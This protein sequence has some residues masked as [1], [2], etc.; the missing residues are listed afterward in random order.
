[1]LLEGL[2]HDGSGQ[3]RA[4]GDKPVNVIVLAA[5]YGTRLYPLTLNTPKPLLAVGG[6]AILERILGKVGEVPA[7]ETILLVTN[8]RFVGH[9]EAWRRGFH[10]SRPIEILN[11]GTTTNENRLGAV[12]DIYFALKQK[13]IDAEVLV[14]GGDN[15]FE[16]D[17]NKTWGFF[18]QQGSSVVGLYDMV[19][20]AKV[21]GLYGVVSV[22]ETSRIIGFQEKPKDPKSALISTAIYFFTKQDLETLRLYIEEANSPDNLGDF[23]RYLI[24]RQTVYGYVFREE[25]FDIGSHDQYKTADAYFSTVPG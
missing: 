20:K 3:F 8:D 11:D 7:V 12:G 22:D 6:K 25:W 21:A 9:F 23:V 17:L 24:E 15:L 19:D 14:V 2:N 5:G 1:M 4:E 10:W 13:G 18:R 16:F